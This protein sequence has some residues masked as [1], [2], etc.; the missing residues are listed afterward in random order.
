MVFSFFHHDNNYY[1]ALSGW[2]VLPHLCYSGSIFLA[3]LVQAI[4]RS[5]IYGWECMK[6]NVYLSISE[7]K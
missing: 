6:K 1:N 5:E 7:S 4:C 2:Y 3:T